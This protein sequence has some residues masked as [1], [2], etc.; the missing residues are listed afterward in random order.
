[1]LSRRIHVVWNIMLIPAQRYSL[2]QA[3]LWRETC[4]GSVLY[5]DRSHPVSDVF[6]VAQVASRSYLRHVALQPSVL[7]V[8]YHI[9]AYDHYIPGNELA[10]VERTC[11]SSKSILYLLS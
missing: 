11:I 2:A 10:N 5:F 8:Q 1:M 7:E 4:T 6:T 3:T 9:R